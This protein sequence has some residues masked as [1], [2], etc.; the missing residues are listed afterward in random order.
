MIY[1]KNTNFFMNQNLTKFPSVPALINN[2][3]VP[4]VSAVISNQ[5]PFLLSFLSFV[6]Y[7]RY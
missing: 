6:H 7:Q 4:V 2:Q 1:S 5:F 3:F